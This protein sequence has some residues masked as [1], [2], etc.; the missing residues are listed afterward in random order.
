MGGELFLKYHF[1]S[2]DPTVIPKLYSIGYASD[3]SV[4]RYGTARR[5]QYLIHDILSGK[6]VFYG[7]ELGCGE[8][9]ITT[10]GIF[11]HYYPS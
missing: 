7:T 5:N 10:P 11:E 2:S 4:T 3:K 9:F 6:G 8:G 1:Y